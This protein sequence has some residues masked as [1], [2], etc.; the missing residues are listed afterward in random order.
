MTLWP[1]PAVE[2]EA[3]AN[4]TTLFCFPGIRRR[5]PLEVR[6]ARNTLEA[7]WNLLQLLLLKSNPSII[8]RNDYLPTILFSAKLERRH[9][10]KNSLSVSDYPAIWHLWYGYDTAT[11]LVI[12]G[13]NANKKT[14]RRFEITTR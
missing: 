1:G 3:A 7:I 9:S 13:I 11:Q 12:T 14:P 6:N 10:S 2:A 4:L 5:D 8:L